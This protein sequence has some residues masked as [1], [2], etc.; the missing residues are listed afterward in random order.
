ML[1][2]RWLTFSI[3]TIFDATDARDGKNLQEEETN[4]IGREESRDDLG[5][6][7]LGS[8]N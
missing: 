3:I 6:L 8:G 2:N 4:E 5:I 1:F 7:T